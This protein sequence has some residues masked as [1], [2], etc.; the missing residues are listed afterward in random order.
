MDDDP[1]KRPEGA[2]PGAGSSGNR[3]DLA[4]PGAEAPRAKIH[5]SPERAVASQNLYALRTCD[6]AHETGYCGALR[7]THRLSL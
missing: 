7:F 6:V 1:A 5:T 2:E 4:K 3:R